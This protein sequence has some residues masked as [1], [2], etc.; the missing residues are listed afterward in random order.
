[1]TDLAYNFANKGLDGDEVLG[2][3]YLRSDKKEKNGQPVMPP[4]L[5]D[6]KKCGALGV[7]SDDKKMSQDFVSHLVYELAY[8]HSPED[9]QLVFFFNKE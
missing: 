2:F 1:M 5:I 9:L 4:L 8:Y 7:I 3:N 6:L